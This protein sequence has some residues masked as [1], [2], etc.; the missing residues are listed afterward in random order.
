MKPINKVTTDLSEWTPLRTLQTY[1]TEIV[2]REIDGAITPFAVVAEAVGA[3]LNSEII[4]ILGFANLLADGLK[5][6]VIIIEK[7]AILNIKNIKHEYLY[8]FNKVCF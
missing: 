5:D 8:F 7:S 4:I 6:L 1:L 3:N 2:Y